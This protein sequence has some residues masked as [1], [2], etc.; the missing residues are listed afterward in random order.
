MK[1]PCASRLR[2]RKRHKLLVRNGN[3]RKD[4]M[5]IKRALLHETLENIER[6]VSGDICKEKGRELS[7]KAVTWNEDSVEVYKR[8]LLGETKQPRTVKEVSIHEQIER[9]PLKAGT[10]D[11]DSVKGGNDRNHSVQTTPVGRNETI[12]KFPKLSSRRHRRANKRNH[13]FRVERCLTD[14]QYHVKDGARR[15]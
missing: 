11:E 15:S 9:E 6:S 1:S 7:L 10:V 5:Q 3:D 14:K 13:E 12:E 4:G 2:R 8:R